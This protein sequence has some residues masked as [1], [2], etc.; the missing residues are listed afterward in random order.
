MRSYEKIDSAASPVVDFCPCPSDVLHTKMSSSLLLT[1]DFVNDTSAEEDAMIRSQYILDLA[2]S[3]SDPLAVSTATAHFGPKP[4]PFLV[5]CLAMR[6]A[7]SYYPDMMKLTANELGDC[8]KS[9]DASNRALFK[10]F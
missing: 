5:F 4:S 3:A 6:T 7:A 9:F 2:L 1:S 10:T 8:W